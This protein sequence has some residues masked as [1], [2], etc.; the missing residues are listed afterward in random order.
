MYTSEMY[1]RVEELRRRQ[2]KKGAMLRTL[3]NDFTGYSDE[4]LRI[5]IAHVPPARLR[6]EAGAFQGSLLFLLA[7]IF[8]LRLVAGVSA[9]LAH[10]YLG[11]VLVGGA[12]FTLIIGVGVWRYR[13]D[14]YV[15]CIALGALGAWRLMRETPFST[16]IAVDVV[17]TLAVVALAWVCKSKLFPD[18]T[19]QGRLRMGSDES[20]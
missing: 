15:T 6:R 18:L 1:R 14:A 8:L 2:M 20:A 3:R 19:W 11:F 5:L 10:D 4:E 7:G 17:G 13:R 16:E 9:V 12:I